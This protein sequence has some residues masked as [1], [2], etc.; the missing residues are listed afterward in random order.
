MQS[1]IYQGKFGPLP[2]SLGKHAE[3]IV[4]STAIHKLDQALDLM[5]QVSIDT[6]ADLVLQ[7]MTHLPA[8]EYGSLDKIG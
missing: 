5:V 7:Y 8:G 3:D 6:A 1:R 4:W 2:L